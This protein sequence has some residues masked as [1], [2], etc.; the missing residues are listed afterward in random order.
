[1]AEALSTSGRLLT[2]LDFEP[3]EFSLLFLGMVDPASVPEDPKDRVS[4]AGHVHRPVLARMSQTCLQAEGHAQCTTQAPSRMLQSSEM[5]V[6]LRICLLFTQVVDCAGYVA[7]RRTCM[8][9]LQ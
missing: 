7:D 6:V 8:P 9:F 5:Q 2:K 1:M 3:M 4:P